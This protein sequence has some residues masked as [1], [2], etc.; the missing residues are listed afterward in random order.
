MQFIANP[1]RRLRDE[2]ASAFEGSAAPQ[3]AA[4]SDCG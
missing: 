2:R 1:R 3:A 4:R